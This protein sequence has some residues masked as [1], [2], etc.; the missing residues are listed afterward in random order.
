MIRLP[1]HEH[2]HHRYRNNHSNRQQPQTFRKT[3]TQVQPTTPACHTNFQGH[4]P[5]TN[6][7][8]TTTPHHKTTAVRKHFV[9]IVESLTMNRKNASPVS[10]IINPVFRQ[11]EIP[12]G[13][14]MS[15]LLLPRPLNKLQGGRRSNRR[16]RFFSTKCYESPYFHFSKV[17]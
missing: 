16:F 9:Y 13:P 1:E 5:S 3:S 17:N 10:E 6:S 15:M 2:L 7:S 14:K 4:K 11:K 12:I 8:A